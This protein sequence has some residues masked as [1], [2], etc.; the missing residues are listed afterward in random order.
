MLTILLDL[1]DTLLANN[2]NS[3]LPAYLSAWSDFMAPHIHPDRIVNALLAGTRAISSNPAIDCTLREGFDQVFYPLVGLTREEFQPYEERFYRQVFPGL[4]SL[5]RPIPGG[6]QLVQNA[7]EQGYQVAIATNPYFPRTAIEQ[8]LE[9]AGLPLEKY[10]F[11]FFPSIET[12]HFG[13]PHIAFFAEMLAHLAWPEGAV[14]MVGDDLD[15]DITPAD[16]FGLATFWVSNTA[17]HRP[18]TLRM[19]HGSGSLESLSDWLDDLLGSGSQPD[20]NSPQAIL[21][22]LQATPAVMSSLC[23]NLSPEQWS[24]HPEPEE[25]CIAEIACHLRDVDIE[26]NLP[27]LKKIIQEDNPF[28]AG[29]DTDRWNIERQYHYQDGLEALQVYIRA[30]Q[31]MLQMLK[32]IEPE[33]WQRTARHSIFG[34]TD[35]TEL[36]SFIAGHDRLHIQQVHNNLKLAS[37]LT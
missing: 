24:Y 13:K 18:A 36:V 8:R 11:A 33:N 34:R 30:R 5:T 10:P 9:W 23:R 19:P 3:F 25:W 26:V 20:I 37:K 22:T 32:A 31:E 6:V 2:M 14:V 1:D 7:F 35:L 27:R 12:A 4:R 17:S 28:L 21:A 29:M 15:L 16:Q